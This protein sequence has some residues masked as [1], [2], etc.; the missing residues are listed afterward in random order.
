MVDVCGHSAKNCEWCGGPFERRAGGKRRRFCST[1]C[2]REFD[3]AL[4]A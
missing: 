2:R 3:G 1:E 4:R